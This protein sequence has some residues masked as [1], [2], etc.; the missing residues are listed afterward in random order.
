LESSC[1]QYISGDSIT[2]GNFIVFANIDGQTISSN[3]ARIFNSPEDLIVVRYHKKNKR[4]G[5]FPDEV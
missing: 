1:N 5:C 3:D 2:K 4:G